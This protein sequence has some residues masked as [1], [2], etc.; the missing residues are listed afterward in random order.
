MTEEAQRYAGLGWPIIPDHN[1]TSEGLCSCGNPEC[2]KVGKHPRISRW[3]EEASTVPARIERWGR[4]WPDMNISV[5]TGPR[6]N[7]AV[8]DVDPRN[9]GS[10]SLHLLFSEEELKALGT[11][12]A[13]TG[14]GGLHIYFRYPGSPFRSIADLLPG[15]E[16]KADGAK[17]TLP[18]SL[19]KSGERYQWER[20]PFGVCP[21][22]LPK[23]IMDL[24]TRKREKDR[25]NRG[26]GEPIREGQRNSQ[27]TAC[28]GGM[29]RQGASLEVIESALLA[30]NKG[31]CTPP[32]DEREVLGIARSAARYTPQ[33]PPQG[34]RAPVVRTAADLEGMVFPPPRW[35]V[36]GLI[37]EGLTILAGSPKVGKSWLA[38][39]LCLVVA[40]G[41]KVLG[42]VET[43]PGE[44]L[45]VALED[46]FS[47]LK[48]RIGILASGEE[49]WPENLHLVN[50]CPR[51][52]QGGIDFLDA[53]LEDHP[54][55]RLVVIDTFQRFRKPSGR[56]SNMYADDYEAAGQLK[57]LADRHHV[58]IL[59]L[60]HTKKG[61]VVDPLEGVSGTMGLSG[62]A[63]TT[64]VL[65]R[66]RGQGR[67]ELFITG[68]DVEERTLALQFEEGLWTVDGNAEEVGLSKQRRQIIDLLKGNA[69]PMSPK[70][71]AEALK[72]PNNSTIRRLLS[73]M[74]KDEQILNL[75][76]R[77]FY[78][79]REQHEHDE[80]CEHHEQH[81]Q[82]TPVHGSMK[83]REQH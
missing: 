48:E 57:R 45:L 12:I 67:A 65:T 56:N 55:I 18:P 47:R 19:H 8:L 15:I 13:R 74:T 16:L 17:V 36:P 23:K 73:N 79:N 28:A 58:G 53:Y 20:P 1:P 71:I 41:E 26:E 82:F 11:P 40:R 83:E 42:S 39:S 46:S 72:R 50:D 76:G 31:Q 61:Q 63:D 64:L 54:E 14:G 38:L 25:S 49:P 24:I 2:S 10:E 77:Y 66:S 37:P 5:L 52:D 62:A 78:Q 27:L 51:A 34:A 6:S 69:K 44:V 60:H 7:L 33:P 70:E 30:M 80:Q 21:A 4:A 75:E 68:R 81:E 22:P 32:L 43:E 3:T 29:R 9:G 35:A 59:V